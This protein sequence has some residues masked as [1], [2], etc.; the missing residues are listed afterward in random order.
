MWVAASGG[1]GRGHAE[2]EVAVG[3]RSVWRRW[4]IWA[5]RVVVKTADKIVLTSA[6]LDAGTPWSLSRVIHSRGRCPL[7]VCAGRIG[8]AGPM[9]PVHDLDTNLDG[10]CHRRRPSFTD[11]GRH[12]R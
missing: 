4:V 5:F 7:V 11:F 8:R 10:W 6:M 3:S 2:V 1:V 12:S 9:S